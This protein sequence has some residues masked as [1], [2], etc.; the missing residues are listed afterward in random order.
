MTE[1]RAMIRLIA[2]LAFLFGVPLVQAQRRISEETIN[3]VVLLQIGQGQGSGFYLRR[4]TNIFLATARHVVGKLLNNQLALLSDSMLATS[5][6]G[7]NSANTNVIKIDL[8]TL[9]SGKNARFFIDRDIAILR[10]AWADGSGKSM[11]TPGVVPLVPRINFQFFADTDV[12]WKRFDEVFVGN[13]VY[14][15][16][17]PGSIGDDQRKQIEYARPLVRKGCLAGRNAMNRTL[18]IDAAAFGGNSGGPVVE[19][20]QVAFQA[21]W[22]LIGIVT[23]LVPFMDQVE[24]NNFSGAITK[25]LSH[26]GYAVVEPIDYVLQLI[27][28][29]QKDQSQPKP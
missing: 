7:T 15:M 28:E 2:I 13:D 10:I 4:D 12:N 26:S 19:Y 16:G 9:V 22:P 6:W 18:I 5:Y 8:K 3:S 24:I 14:M 11:P 21:R 27:S 23:E 29:W 25:R 1:N 17:Y 20:D